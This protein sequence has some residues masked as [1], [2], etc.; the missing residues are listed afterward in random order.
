M[1]E[2]LNLGIN[3]FNE[4]QDE[5]VEYIS[6][7]LDY[8]AEDAWE[9]LKTVRFAEDVRGVRDNVVEK[10]TTVLKKAG[11]LGQDVGMKGMVGIRRTE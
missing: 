3:H 5:A 11:V 8:S 9:W 10:T 4:H 6:T 2:K 7:E 1:L